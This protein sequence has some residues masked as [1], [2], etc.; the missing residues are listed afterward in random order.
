M[1]SRWYAVAAGTCVGTDRN[2]RRKAELLEAFVQYLLRSGVHDLSLRPAAAALK[3]S[4]RMLIYYFGSREQL[5]FKAIAEI[6]A[7]ERKHFTRE[8]Q[9]HQEGTST[10]ELL[11]ASW[12]WYA[13]KR[14]EPYLRLMFELYG[15]AFVNPR[16]YQGF[17]TAMTED[18]FSMMEAGLRSQGLS[19]PKSRVA[20]T[21][22]RATL[23]GLLMDVL[24]TGDRARVEEAVAELAQSLARDLASRAGDRG[25]HRPSESTGDGT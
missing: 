20:A 16:R 3:T 12:R 11:Q 6:R 10:T 18:H 4:P 14:R 21:L 8:V 17:L 5:L 23:R 24:A 2:Q 25:E 13:S 15:L 1:A 22:Y 7:M 19:P 9:H